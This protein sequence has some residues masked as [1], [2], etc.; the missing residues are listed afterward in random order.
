MAYV[1]TG[2]SKP[3][4][5]L[6]SNPSGTNVFSGGKLLARGVSV[7]VEADVVDDNNFYADN[8]LAETET[9][10]VSGGTLTLTVDGLDATVRRLI[11]GLPTA[12]TS[13]GWVAVGDQATLPFCGVGFIRRTMNNGTTNYWAVVFPKCKFKFNGEDA[14]TQEDQI[15]WQTT[16]LEAAFMRDDT[17]NHN[18][19][20]VNDTAFATEAQAEAA[21]KTFL[22]IT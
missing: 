11:Y 3:Y 1:T 22:S 17:S 9:G 6:Y 13:T 7:S 20:Y 2:F 15:S 21:I 12:A 5:A 18:W 16:E 4:V 19:K 8:I 14:E 10:A